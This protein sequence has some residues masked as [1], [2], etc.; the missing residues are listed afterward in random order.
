MIFNLAV[1]KGDGIG[2]EIVEQAQRILVKIGE[3]YNHQFNFNEVLAG[4]AAIDAVGNCIPDSTL[5]ACKKSD[6]VILGAVGGP[7]WDHL[8]GEQ[9][10]EKGLLTI[11][12]ELGLFANIRPAVM[13]EELQ[14]ACPLKPEIV[15]DGLDIV[16]VRELTGGIYFGKKESSQ[17]YACDRME[18][19]EYEIA[20]ITEK[21]FQI[22]MKRNKKVTS[23]DKANVLETSRM[24]RRTVDKIAKKYPE[25]SVEHMYVD[26]AAMQ[27]IVNPSQFD[28]ILTENMFGDILS[29]EASMITGS[30]GMLPSASLGDKNFGMYEPIHGSA[31]DIAGQNKANPIATILSMAMMLRYS[32]NLENEANAIENA[33]RSTLKEGYRTAD[34]TKDNHYLGTKEITDQILQYI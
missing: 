7:K 21:A 12:K 5:E 11:R 33:V 32:F 27:L 15:K 26:N 9:R 2:P 17:S 1:I 31:P 10:P 30:I 25:V 29:D 8:K 34:I 3:K 16:I 28:V 24:W 20:R 4:G 6:A 23:V 18:Y 19:W 14:D 22:A 13:F